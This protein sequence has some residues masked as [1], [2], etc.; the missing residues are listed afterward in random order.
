[1]HGTPLSRAPGQGHP[2][3]DPGY[4]EEQALGSSPSPTG[5]GGGASPPSGT[6]K[7]QQGVTAVLSKKPGA[8][9]GLASA[10]CTWVALGGDRFLTQGHTAMSARVPCERAQAECGGG[11]RGSYSLLLPTGEMTSPQT[12][13]STVVGERWVALEEGT[14][15][16]CCS[17]PEPPTGLSRADSKQ[18]A[19]GCSARPASL[20]C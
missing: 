10:R 2:V 20:L 5:Q 11:L 4:C 7:L 18:G 13:P 15:S 1:M 19:H 12:S 16:S 17:F 8:F 9:W 6:R 14:F 3:R